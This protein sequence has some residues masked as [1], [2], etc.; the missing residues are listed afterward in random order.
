MNIEQER[1]E[2]LKYYVKENTT[3]YSDVDTAFKDGEFRDAVVQRGFKTWLAAKENAKPLAVI[4][5]VNYKTFSNLEIPWYT[6]VG[7]CAK[8]E[9]QTRY[10][11]E[12]WALLNGYRL[13]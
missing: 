3:A 9:H 4:K 7:T 10:A 13:E 1:Q 6:V 2:F 12:Q 11:C 5:E 8:C